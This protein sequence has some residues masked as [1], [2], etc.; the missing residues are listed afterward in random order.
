MLLAANSASPQRECTVSS[1]VQKLF[2][3]GGPQN[4]ND[5]KKMGWRKYENENTQA[6]QDAVDKGRDFH[7]DNTFE[8]NN[9]QQEK[10]IASSHA[11]NI[12][13]IGN[14]NN[15]ACENCN[16]TY[17][18]RNGLWKHKK[19]CNS[20]FITINKEEYKKYK[21]YKSFVKND[22]SL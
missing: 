6:G 5:T 11:G 21:K 16:N 2:Q 19:I 14:G 7:D 8:E 22:K 13:N 1:T 10:M 17:K 20:E 18:T 4:A 3:V 12:G 15:F 9:L